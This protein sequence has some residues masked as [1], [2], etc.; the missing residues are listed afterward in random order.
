MDAECGRIL[1]ASYSVL[2][3][4]GTHAMF[5][6]FCSISYMK[7]FMVHARRGTEGGGGSPC[8]TASANK[9]SQ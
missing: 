3:L 8:P 7:P 2:S 4:E 6:S 9:T 5:N 1:D